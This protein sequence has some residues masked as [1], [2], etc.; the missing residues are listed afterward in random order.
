VDIENISHYHIVEKLGGGGMGVVYKAEDTH[1]HRFVALKFLPP[2]LAKDSGALARFQR[3]A[4]AASG[5][6]HPNICT[7]YDIDEENG[8]AFIAMEYLEGITLKHMI[9]GQPLEP[10]RLLSL[11]IEIADAL[12]AAHSEGII[13]RDIKPTNIL[14]TKRG[15]AKIMDFGL[16]KVVDRRSVAAGATLD[17]TLEDPLTSPGTALGTIA[18]MSPEQAMGKPLDARSD[19]FSLGLTLYEMATGKQAFVG[20]TSAAIFDAILHSNPPS[21]ERINPKL[22][23]GLNQ[24]I[25]KLIEK[26]PDLR[27]Q[28]AADLRAD[29]KRW[30]RDTTSG[31]QAAAIVVAETRKNK[32]PRWGW[33]TIGAVVLVIGAIVVWLYEAAP[34][35]YSGLPPRL[36]PFT[37]TAGD[38][39]D[40]AFS[41]DGNEIAFSWQGENS[42]DP[43]V[44][45][46]YVQL[47]GAGTP[48]KITSV[49]AIDRCSSWSPDG[50]FIAFLRLTSNGSGYYIIPALGGPE[51]RVADSYE[52]AGVSWSPDGKYLAV[53]DQVSKD[54]ATLH[55][56]MISVDSGERRDSKIDIPGPY[57]VSP[58][59]SPDGKHIAFASGSGFLSTD[60]YVASS[61]GG[62]PSR[63]TS[64][65]AVIDSLAWA[66]DGQ[67]LVFNSNHRGLPALWRVPLSGEVDP[68][69]LVFASDYSYSPAISLRGDRLAFL[70]YQFDTNIWRA[71]VP[72][73]DHSQPIKLIASTSEDAAPSYSPDGERIAFASTR[74]GS[75][76]IYVANVDGSNQ[77]QLTSMKTSDTGSPTWS[78]DGR[79][80]AFD[81]RGEGNG[82]IYVIG[83]QGGTPRR[84]TNGPYDNEL[85]SWSHDGHWI[86]YSSVRS[87]QERVWKVPA[88]GGDPVQITRDD[89]RR[90]LESRDGKFLYYARDHAVWRSALNGAGEV[91]FANLASI[92]DFR[93]CGNQICILDSSLQ[94]RGRLFI[95][96]AAGRSQLQRELDIGPRFHGGPGVDFSP[97]GRWV[98][99]TRAD[100]IQSDL[101]LVE[102]FH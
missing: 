51:R 94:P 100:S 48:L 29:L 66:A 41:P 40:P 93:I 62:R 92:A 38:K 34:T 10:E 35:K 32:V 69:P 33:V 42:K 11:G 68:Q 31:H 53:V 86:Y 17:A 55:I 85:P 28:T 102:N 64:V 3:E 79:Q 8:R 9:T 84:L 56:F 5:L 18:Y 37:S 20:N 98:V 78:P 46:L 83:S 27:Y 13:H 73:S 1:L 97:D 4:Q 90:P 7:I 59:F 36:V 54:D 14:V 15:H 87:G 82:D 71:P 95:C 60:V 72:R 26:D 61:S 30:H 45:N 67:S 101:M 21:A 89:G 50:R 19:L 70:H 16:A 57:L 52:S 2:E 63:L 81:S 24:I 23:A 80:I 22:P 43:N 96:D 39:F 47:V 76:E 99:Y 91:R 75:F 65:H 77:I 58:E 25:T 44:Y 12:D 49:P 88:G 6:N 74:S